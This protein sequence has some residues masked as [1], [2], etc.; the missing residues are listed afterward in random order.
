[1]LPVGRRVVEM[2]KDVQIEEESH[3]LSFFERYLTVWVLIC[4]GAGTGLGFLFPNLDQVL[5]S[6]KYAQ[7]SLPIAVALF[8]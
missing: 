6:I 5:D 7:V 4:M 2:N 1:M 3:Q 8:L